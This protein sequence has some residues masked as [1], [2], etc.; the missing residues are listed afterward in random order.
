MR[1]SSEKGNRQFRNESSDA[2][3]AWSSMELLN[4]MMTPV[5]TLTNND[6]QQELDFYANTQFRYSNNQSNVSTTTAKDDTNY[7]DLSNL[8]G[9]PQ[10]HS[11]RSQSE[12]FTQQQALRNLAL[13]LDQQQ[14]R[15]SANM[16]I[17]LGHGM[18][19]QN[20][21]SQ[22]H[23]VNALYSS[24]PPTISQPSHRLPSFTPDLMDYTDQIN[25]VLPATSSSRTKQMNPPEK[26]KRTR[27]IPSNQQTQFR[28]KS[29]QL[30]R[31]N[32]SDNNSIKDKK[33]PLDVNMLTQHNMQQ[34]MTATRTITL[35]ETTFTFTI[36]SL[37]NTNKRKGKQKEPNT[38]RTDIED[39]EMLDD[40]EEED[41]ESDKDEE[42][43]VIGDGALSFSSIGSSN[44]HNSQKKSTLTKDDKRRRNTAASARF[45]IKKKMKEQ[46]LQKTACE[47]TEKAQM[48]E[49]KV[50]ELE[51][52]IKWL[53]A[54]VVEKN[55]STLEK[56][57]RDR[58]PNSIAFPLPSASRPLLT[59][60]DYQ[61]MEKED[62]DYPHF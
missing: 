17:L 16:D 42:E 15:S 19:D 48:M 28:F 38:K 47:M 2:N 26:P 30:D 35:G 12:S 13:A 1:Q 53:K 29:D 8:N 33:K 50:H 41:Q 37:L 40:D 57:I 20:T 59:Q 58:P 56:L 31:N 60:Y 23:P 46:A 34:E 51:R 25:M 6:L 4:Q 36:D 55:E 62:S 7:L 3:S 24:S 32:Q 61:N 52:E 10:P 11:F 18:P 43:P 21:N 14:R 27:K 49:N 22:R 5:Q 45:R 9:Q 54:L 39:E 44:S